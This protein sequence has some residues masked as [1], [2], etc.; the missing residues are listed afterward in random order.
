M[1]NIILYLNDD[2]FISK[3]YPDKN[4]SNLDYCLIGSKCSN[5][6]VKEKLITFFKVRI[7]DILKDKSI[8]KAELFIHID[9]NKNHIFKE[10]VDIE[11]KRISEYYNLR[12]IT[13][14]DRVSM[15]NIRGYLPIGISDTSNYICLNIT[16]TIKAWAMNKYPNYGLALS[17]NYPYQ[18]LEFTSSRGCNKPY[19]LVTFEDRII[20]NCYPKCECLPIRITGPMGPRGA[21]GSTGP[22]GVTG[23]T[24]NTGATGSIGPTGVTGPTGSIGPTG[25]TGSTG[26]TGATG[27]IG[28]TGVTGPTGNTGV[29][30]S[31]GPTG[32][33]GPTGNT[34]EIGP[35]GATGPTGPT[36][37]I[38]PTGATGPTGNTGVMGEIGPTGPTGN[39]GVTGEIGP[40][41]VTGPTGSIGPTGVTGP[42]GATG[43]IGPTGVTG[44][45]GATGSI[46]PTG[47]TGPTGATGSIGP[48]GATGATGVTGPTGPTGATG[49]SSQPVANFLVNAPS[50][51]TLNNGDAITGWQTIIGNSSSITV[52]ANGTFTVQENGVYY[53]SVSV[54]LQPGSSSINQYSFAILFPILGGKDL[55]GLTTEPGG[56][57]VLSGYFAGFLFGG[58][59]FTINNFSSTTVGIRNGQSA[60]TAATLT[61]FRIADTVMT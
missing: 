26:S 20:D 8:L 37:S 47:V 19:I 55:A 17:L 22:T 7:P 1:R 25:V 58:T 35:T 39:T 13:W 4:F 3:K 2:T 9:S 5:S 38:G 41:G 54:A 44:P 16:G 34:G 53:I 56:G 18:I 23:P 29:T 28:P 51:Q 15:E 45:T 57:G 31:I 21:T 32:V 33:T 12:T 36:G 61:I 60:G 59:T 50:P 10:K 42:T 14:N 6:F 24:G 49:N 43:S 46:G 30:G 48:T 40:T 52:D 27:S 11:I